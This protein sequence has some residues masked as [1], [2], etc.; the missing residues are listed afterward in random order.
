M[1][2]FKTVLGYN[3]NKIIEIH[4]LEIAKLIF[5]PTEGEVMLFE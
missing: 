2:K 4:L 1:L 5:K 3:R